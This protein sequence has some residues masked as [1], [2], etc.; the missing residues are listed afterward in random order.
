MYR[1]ILAL[2]EMVL[3]KEYLSTLTSINNL[4]GVLSR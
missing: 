1:Q 4:A 3:G 2:M